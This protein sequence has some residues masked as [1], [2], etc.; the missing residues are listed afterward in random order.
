MVNVVL[1]SKTSCRYE[2]FSAHLNQTETD[3]MW[4]IGNTPFG[5]FSTSKTV[6]FAI[7]DAAYVPSLVYSHLPLLCALYH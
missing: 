1:Q 5:Y 3:W 6:S 7:K 4:A 2:H